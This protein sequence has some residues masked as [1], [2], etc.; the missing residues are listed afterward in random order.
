MLDLTFFTS[1]ATKLAHARY[2]AERWPLRIVGF[3]QRTY[4]AD[5]Y[6]PR[7]T[8]RSELLSASYKSALIQCEKAGFATKNHLFFL[9]DTSVRITA[10][11]S[12][13][14]DVP[15]L[16][17]KYWMQDQTFE[18]LDASLKRAGNCRHAVVRSDV[19]LHVPDTYKPQWGIV[20][21]YLVFTAT[22]DGDV[23]DR[24]FTF[25]TNLVFPW[26]DNK[27]FN[28]WFQPTGTHAPLGSLEITS[29]DK[30]DFRRGSFEKLFRFLDSKHLLTAKPT[31]LSLH[32]DDTPNFILCGYTCAGKTTAGQYLA[33]R[34]GYLHVEASDFMYLN[35]YYRHG[36]QDRVSIEEFAKEALLQKPHI[37]AERIADYIEE[38]LATPVVIT[39]FRSIKE[40][41]WL[42]DKLSYS[43][44]AFRTI[45]VETD[46]VTRF[47]RMRARGRPGD[48]SAFDEFQDRDE[49]QKR[50][51]LENWRESGQVLLLSNDTAMTI[52]QERLDDQVGP[53]RA[54]DFAVP[55]AVELLEA[56]AS[57]KLEDSILI[58][59]LL[60]GS[61]DGER[62]YYTTT[63][64][65][66]TINRIFKSIQPKHKDNV[67]RYFNQDFYA[68][69]EIDND[70]EAELKKYRLSNTGRG[71]ALRTLASLCDDSPV[72][73][74][75]N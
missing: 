10:L 11:S 41:E 52:Y 32:L 28:K 19:L 45:F 7:V 55:N 72:T 3:R 36:V 8:T 53:R 16:D 43:G 20:D 73:G 47:K 5:Y 39:G 34:Y 71:R 48:D 4:H 27:S 65:A 67:S 56:K 59:L 61:N 62:D 70:Q 35:Y 9:E 33:K 60:V 66:A 23:V 54:M 58:A 17:V 64:I 74:K 22:Q 68:Y 63:Q 25:T 6:E 1:N 75:S 21:D 57:V 24:E 18:R 2:I 69:Y 15:G 29:A 51:G 40:A 46:Q 14:G 26:L 42:T 49:Q 50:M 38:Y 12:A 30:V 37:A 31:Q 44:K 13:D